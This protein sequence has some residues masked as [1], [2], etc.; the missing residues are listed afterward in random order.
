L[1]VVADSLSGMAV[2]SREE[3]VAA[4]DAFRDAVSG[5]G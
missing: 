2:S 4:F 5:L 1:P 3:I